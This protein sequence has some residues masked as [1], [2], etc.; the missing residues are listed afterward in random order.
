MKSF[1]HFNQQQIFIK[2]RQVSRSYVVLFAY[3]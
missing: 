3:I 2:G 1:I